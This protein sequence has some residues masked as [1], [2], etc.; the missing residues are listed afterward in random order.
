M[1]AVLQ[2]NFRNIGRAAKKIERGE[3]VIQDAAT[4]LDVDLTLPWEACFTPGQ[5]TV[6][7]MVFNSKKTPKMCC[8]NCHDNNGRNAQNVVK[9]EEIEW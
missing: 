3:F 8:P 2:S 6:M 5:H 7:S 1:T 9:D 4:K